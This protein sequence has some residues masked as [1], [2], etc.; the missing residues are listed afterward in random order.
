MSL[1]KNQIG[2]FSKKKKKKM[3]SVQQIAVLISWWHF[4]LSLKEQC[5]PPISSVNN[6]AL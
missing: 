2:Y 1:K 6:R 5:R 4:L 3:Y